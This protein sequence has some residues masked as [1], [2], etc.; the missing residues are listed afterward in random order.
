MK[1]TKEVSDIEDEGISRV[2]DPVLQVAAV[3]ADAFL[4]GTSSPSAQAPAHHVVQAAFACCGA[5]GGW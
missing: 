2:P 3:A 1:S 4:V 5:D